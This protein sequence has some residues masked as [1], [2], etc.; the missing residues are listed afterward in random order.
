[1]WVVTL[2]KK[3]KKKVLLRLHQLKTTGIKDIIKKNLKI[4]MKII[5][6]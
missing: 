1:M 5:N 4:E 6:H 3:K 2:E